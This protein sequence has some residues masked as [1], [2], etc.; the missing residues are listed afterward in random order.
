[1]KH[2]IMAIALVTCIP[3]AADLK[4]TVKPLPIYLGKDG[5]QMNPVEAIRASIAGEKV[6]KCELVE[7]QASATGNVS[8]KKVK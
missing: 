4:M 8:M 3:A 1:M 6:L 7:A 2:V 5:K